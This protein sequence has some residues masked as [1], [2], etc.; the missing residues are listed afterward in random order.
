MQLQCYHK[1]KYLNNDKY[2]ICLTLNNKIS[3]E[4]LNHLHKISIQVS[5]IIKD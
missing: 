3:N 1:K 4:I 2:A 5:F